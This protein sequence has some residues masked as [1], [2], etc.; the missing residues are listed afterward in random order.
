MNGIALHQGIPQAIST[1]EKYYEVVPSD[2]ADGRVRKVNTERDLK[3]AEAD[4]EFA[5]KEIERGFPLLHAHTL[6]G[7][8]GAFEAAIEDCVVGMLMNEPDVLRSEAFSKLRIPLAEF[9]LLEKEDRMRVLLAEVGRGQGLGKRQGV[10]SFE[11]LLAHA[12][13]SGVVDPEVKKTM[14][15]MHHVR[16]VSSWNGGRRSSV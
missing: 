14:W 4:A 3:R 9:E 5:K 12:K 10:D 6:V 16:N 11:S 13:L 1:L 7:L 8:W 15:E 2:E